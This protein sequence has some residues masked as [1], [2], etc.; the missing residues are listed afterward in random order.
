MRITKP[1]R[2][3]KQ[4]FEHAILDLGLIHIKQLKSHFNCGSTTI[5]KL[6]N[7]YDL[8][9]T[10]DEARRQASTE[11][12]SLK[13]KRK[14]R[15]IL[16]SLRSIVGTDKR[17]G[18]VIRAQNLKQACI[19]LMNEYGIYVSQPSHIIACCRGERKSAYNYTWRWDDGPS[20][21]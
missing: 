8:R 15:A 16:Y 21:Q 9:E 17:S 3:T 2:I 10:L 13:R 4:D 7:A 5:Q 1:S 11:K 19:I 12:Q 14:P 20:D 6:L 18:Q